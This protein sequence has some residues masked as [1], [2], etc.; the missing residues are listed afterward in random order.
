MKKHIVHILAVCM[1]LML[2]AAPALA[3]APATPNQKLALRT[4]PNTKYVELF[5]LPQSTEITAIEYEEGNG[6][7][8]VLVEFDYKG[9]RMRGYTGLKRM[10]VHGDIPWADHAWSSVETIAAADVYAAPAYDAALRGDI[11]YMEWVQLLRFDG[12]FV[13]IEYTDGAT[14]DPSRGWIERW[15]LNIN[16]NEYYDGIQPSYPIVTG[17]TSIAMRCN[18]MTT[19]YS[20]PDFT[21][22]T[23]L[24]IP[25]NAVVNC[26][27]YLYSG[28]YI[29]EYNGC[30]GYVHSSFI[31]DY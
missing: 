9:Q 22:P 5:T 13:Y 24:I 18:A 2:W 25:E 30:L 7:T 23:S 14:G 12:D 29:V 19:L 1:A 21:S 27:G 26:F 15:A 4:G 16:S 6:V 17:D 3:A 10:T 20:M 8:W 28:F 11:G 31:S